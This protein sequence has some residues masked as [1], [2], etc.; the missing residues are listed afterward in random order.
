MSD[1]GAENILA[2]QNPV[3]SRA[4]KADEVIGW[5][6]D[7][8]WGDDLEVV[9]TIP[10]DEGSNVDLIREALEPGMT[11]L[12]LGGDGLEHDLFNAIREADKAGEVGADEVAMLPVPTGG[13]NDLSHSLYGGNI[14]RARGKVLWDILENGYPVWLDGIKLEDGDRLDR[15]AHS[16]VSFGFT[17]QVADAVNQPD[18]RDR[19]A[20]FNPAS[21]R[22]LDATA[23]LKA[24]WNREPFHYENGHGPTH[25]QEVLYSLAP[26]I[27]AGVVRLDKHLR[28]GEL[29]HL[30]V[31]DRAFLPKAVARLASGL[32]GGARAD[33]AEGEQRL[34][35]HTPVTVQYDGEPDVLPADS[36]V[37]ISHRREVVRALA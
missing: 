12:G 5:L 11:V 27:G 23:V 16:Y 8:P 19:R 22:A 6:M 9:R 7:S 3:C 29:A 21:A 15:Y 36:T 18:Y 32:L 25:A 33:Y 20:G 17:A 31:G 14:L 1:R 34:V 10:P 37:N 30:E 2:I 26:R 4:A 13:G 24:L 35:F 28:D